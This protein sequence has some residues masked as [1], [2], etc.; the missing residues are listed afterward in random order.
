MTWIRRFVF[1]VAAVALLSGCEARDDNDGAGD[2]P[3]A[4]VDDSGWT[5]YN[6]V[7]RYPNIAF[8]C[9]GPNGLYTARNADESHARMFQV[10]PND[11]NC[12]H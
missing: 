2:A 9:V 11:P 1:A 8:K 12:P 7:D 5:V 3:I 6:G 10:V 4:R